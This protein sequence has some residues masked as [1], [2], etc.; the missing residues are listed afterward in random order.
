MLKYTKNEWQIIFAAYAYEIHHA[1]FMSDY[2]YDM[3]ARSLTDNTTIPGFDASTGMW[4]NDLLKNEELLSILEK[5]YKI[6]DGKEG[7]CISWLLPVDNFIKAEEYLRVCEC[8]YAIAEIRFS[9]DTLADSFHIG[10]NPC[11]QIKVRP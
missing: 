5:A 4:I 10:N 6:W 8:G 11:K 3:S 1:N 7:T 9:N 2:C